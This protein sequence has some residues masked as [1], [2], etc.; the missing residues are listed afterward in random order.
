MQ[1]QMKSPVI[2][3][4]ETQ[5]AARRLVPWIGLWIILD[6]GPGLIPEWW[7]E[8]SC[9]H[10]D[11]AISNA[12][13]GFFSHG[14]RRI[15]FQGKPDL[16]SNQSADF[17]LVRLLF[18]ASNHVVSDR[19]DCRFNLAGANRQSSARSCLFRVCLD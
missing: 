7:I 11:A 15:L 10:H 8:Q 3:H 2:F 18:H 13:T 1:T 16:F 6:C 9:H 14:F 19:S 4:F 12:F 17:A 5:L